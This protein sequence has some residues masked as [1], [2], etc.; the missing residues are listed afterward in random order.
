[1]GQDL[2]YVVAGG[3]GWLEDEMRQTI[4]RT[5]MNDYVHLLGLVEDRDLPALYSGARLLA[6]VSLYEGFGLPALEAMA[7]GT[8]VVTSNLSS[9]PE[10][11]GEAALL[12]DP[13]DTG[14]IRDAIVKLE[15]DADRRAQLIQAGF[16]QAKRFTWMR[17][18]RQLQSIYDEMLS[19]RR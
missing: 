9:L 12:V 4:E 8:P 13:Y 16:L 17:A 7:C 19:M 1:M 15:T 6:M 3:S 2:H 11:G 14:A 5:E 18:A 10:V